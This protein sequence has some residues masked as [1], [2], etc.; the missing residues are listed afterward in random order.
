MFRDK[1]VPK[2]QRML[3]QEFE[4]ILAVLPKVQPDTNE[5]AKMLTSAER[6]YG[7][8]NIK[9]SPSVSRETLVTVGANLLG[10]LLIIKHEDVNVITSKALGFVIRV[11]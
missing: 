8:M 5:F 1:E 2:H 9:K 11:R 6:I 10:I 4:H 3:E 7:M